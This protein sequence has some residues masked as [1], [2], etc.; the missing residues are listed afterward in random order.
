ME[1]FG[2]A[3]VF[4]SLNSKLSLLHSKS[5][6]DIFTDYF[7]SFPSRKK[8]FTQTI[9]V[10]GI[11]SGSSLGEIRVTTD[12]SNDINEVIKYF[13]EEIRII[14]SEMKQYRAATNLLLEQHQKSIDEIDNKITQTANLQNQK[15]RE[16]II[17]DP[18]EELGGI[19]I[20]LFGI[21]Y[22]NF[23]EECTKIA[24]YFI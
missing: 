6:R 22:G 5:I 12:P 16:L 11:S 20:L 14:R 9:S 7:R 2:L 13:K 18:G 8:P 3:L 19:T 17:S 21:L 10:E 4:L 1:I 15:I 23:S 24:T